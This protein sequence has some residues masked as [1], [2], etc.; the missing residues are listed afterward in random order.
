MP[1]ALAKKK[2]VQPGGTFR[3][4]AQWSLRRAGGLQI[5]EAP[6]LAKLKWLMHGFSTRVGGTSRLQVP[7][8]DE[9]PEE[10]ILNLGFTDWDSRERVTQNRRKFFGA[11]G[12]SK[13]PVIALRQIS[14][15]YRASR[16][17]R[18]CF[19]AT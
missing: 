16:G 13:M 11:I 9:K 17:Q 18:P 6:P 3:P 1:T 19:G 4:A 12:A 15:R 7:V 2:R 14:F 10:K 8:R 5:L